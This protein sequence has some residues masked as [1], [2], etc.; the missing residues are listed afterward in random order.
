MALCDWGDHLR[1]IVL[2]H[3]ETGRYPEVNAKLNERD[4]WKSMLH[5]AGLTKC[6]T[7]LLEI[8]I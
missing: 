3:N 7:F 5:V 6:G 1:D 4:T 8:Q 2:G